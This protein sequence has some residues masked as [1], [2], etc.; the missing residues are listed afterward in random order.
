MKIRQ[1]AQ[2]HATLNRLIAQS[3]AQREKDGAQDGRE[4]GNDKEKNEKT[5]I[6]YC[7]CVFRHKN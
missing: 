4:R 1:C 5:A 3:F 2:G 7:V 6:Q